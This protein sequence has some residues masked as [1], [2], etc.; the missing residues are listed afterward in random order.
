MMRS[1]AR[2]SLASLLLVV[3]L[4]QLPAVARA[5]QQELPRKRS[6]YYVSGGLSGALT[7]WWVEDRDDTWAGNTAASF[8]F[9]E[10]LTP[11]F[12]LG[13]RMGFALEAQLAVVGIEGQWEFVEHLAVRTGIGFGLA[14]AEKDPTDPDSEQR[15]TASAGYSVALSYDIF[16]GVPTL[17]GGLSITPV[18]EARL[19]PGDGVGALTT[20]LGVELTYWT[21][22]PRDQLKLPD[23]E[24]YRPR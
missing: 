4:T 10:M 18:V 24:A 21:G 23:S 2:T 16:V 15:G 5:Q 8:R 1:Y 14:V 13:L 19:V 11:H 20:L 12:G 9:G 22:R 6:G 3:G 17:S 7:R